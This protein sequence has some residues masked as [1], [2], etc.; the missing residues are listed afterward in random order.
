MLWTLG[1]ILS[2]CGLAVWLELACIYPRSG[3]E[4]GE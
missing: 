4:K 2:L 3:G 1:G